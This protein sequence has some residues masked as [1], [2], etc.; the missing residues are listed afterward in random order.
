MQ[1]LSEL[2]KGDSLH[3]FNIVEGSNI[4]AITK[5]CEIVLNF[6]IHGNP[7]YFYKKYD[8]FLIDDA[9]ELTQLQNRKHKTGEPAVFVIECGAINVASQNALLK[10]LEESKPETYFFMM[11]PQSNILLPTFLS[12][13]VVYQTE[14]VNSDNSTEKEEKFEFPNYTDIQKMPIGER[15]KLITKWLDQYKKEKIQKSDMKKFLNYLKTEMHEKGL[16]DNPDLIKQLDNINQ[17]SDLF[18]I[19]GAHIK[20]ILEF[21]VLTI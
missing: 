19:N 18:D 1:N 6:N 4:D 3:H 14:F 12:R 13:A 7:N 21:V 9:R 8:T 5:T 17:V 20:S 11:L 2:K 16:N 15:M 10:V